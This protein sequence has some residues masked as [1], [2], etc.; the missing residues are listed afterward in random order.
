MNTK[1]QSYA[2]AVA[3]VLMALIFILSGLSKIGAGT[4]TLGGANTYSG[5]T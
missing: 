5:V 4:L 2:M 1:T 3:R